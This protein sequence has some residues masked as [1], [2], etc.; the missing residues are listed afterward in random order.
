MLKQTDSEIIKELGFDELPAEEQN[1]RLEQFYQ[2]LNIR[3]GMAIEDKLSD[4]QLAELANLMDDQNA[5]NDWLEKTVPDYETIVKNELESL[6]Q[7]IKNESSQIKAL[8][9][10]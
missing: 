7:E 1:R 2:T 10:N 6:K 5:A 3:V 4:E 9:N 8:V